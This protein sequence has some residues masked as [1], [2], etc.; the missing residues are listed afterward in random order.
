MITIAS[1]SPAEFE[2][3]GVLIYPGVKGYDLDYKR[4]HI[5][6]QLATLKKEGIIDFNELLEW[7]DEKDGLP[8]DP[9]RD[10]ELAAEIAEKQA[11]R[12]L[13]I[14][15]GRK[16]TAE[17]MKE[18]PEDRKKRQAAARKKAAAEAKVAAELKAKEEAEAKKKAAAK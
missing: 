6:Y 10:K 5:K 11:A 18:K 3:D 7:D 16:R 2:I 1:K 15:E 9:K 14:K 12:R 8:V 13:R 4:P 17:E